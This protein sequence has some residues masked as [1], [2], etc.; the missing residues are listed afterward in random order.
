MLEGVF[1]LLGSI[2]LQSSSIEGKNCFPRPL[3]KDVEQTLLLRLYNGDMRAR[4]ELVE[5]NMR[6]VV[7]VVKKYNNYPDTDELISVGS[8]GLLKAIDTYSAGK[9]TALAT[10]AA[11]CIENEILMTLRSNKKQKND[12]SLYEPITYD[13]E[14]NEITLMDLLAIDEESVMRTVECEMLAEKLREIMAQALDEREITTLTMRYGLFGTSQ[15]TQIE[16]ADKLNISRSYIS[17]IEKKSLKKLKRYMDIR[18]V[19]LN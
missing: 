1:A 6:L 4:E 2:M 9:G 3:D 19:N 11:R 10:Y 8:I 18:G 7:H 17:R 14:G 5:H 13:K 12:R 16:V 15:Y